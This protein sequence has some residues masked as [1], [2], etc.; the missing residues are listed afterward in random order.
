MR[1]VLKFMPLLLILIMVFFTY[2]QVL[3]FDYLWD[4]DL[5]I[6]DNVDLV[7]SQLNWDIISRPVLQG[8]S[9]FRPLVFL[10]WFIEFKLFG[11]SSATS[12]LINLIIFLINIGLVY[13]LAYLLGKATQKENL[14]LLASLC[15]GLYAIHPIHV[16]TTAWV[17]GR[18][19][20]M[21]TLFTLLACILFISQWLR[22][23]SS[24]YINF[25]IGVC[26][27]CA[28]MSK[29]LGLVV[30]ILIFILYLAVCSDG[31]RANFIGF[32][33]QY[34][35]LVGFIGI[36]F[37]IY[38]MLRMYSM[39]ETYHYPF[40]WEYYNTI[41]FDQ[42]VPLYAIKQY[43]LQALLPFYTLGPIQPTELFTVRNLINII[44][45]IL[46]SIFLIY[47][48]INAVR[49]NSFFS[50]MMLS[51][52]VTISLVIF[53]IPISSGNNI[54]QERFMTLGLTF[55][56][57]GIVF[58]LSKLRKKSWKIL[59]VTFL[60]IWSIGAYATTKSILPFWKNE[61][62]LWGWVYKSYPNNYIIRNLYY[63][64]LLKYN[65]LD[66]L[67]LIVNKNTISQ[68]KSLHI[69]DQV[70]Y[71]KALLIRRHPES[72]EYLRGVITSI[73]EFHKL[74][75]NNILSNALNASSYLQLT[76]LQIATA[77]DSLSIA[78]LWFEN[79][80]EQALKYNYIAEQYLEPSEKYPVLYNRIAFFKILGRQEEVD[81]LAK[82]VDM[83]EMYRK[84]DNVQNIGKIIKIWCEIN[85]IQQ[86]CES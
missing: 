43:F 76:P 61:M 38:Y 83:I 37:T 42:Q 65:H 19:D 29:E 35:I 56:I 6:V 34:Y 36:F 86:K 25:L 1:I 24:L 16:E 48:A 51:Y 15:A 57:I 64:S 52:L 77:Y 13:W 53:L 70:L 22:S 47:L 68:G 44:S 74:D 21:A 73:P 54:I 72:L 23:Q 17:S 40:T 75:S 8:S 80:P 2:K 18:F 12:H 27:F 49:K 39:Q 14:V 84:N 63:F 58:T 31:F 79:N 33:K 60:L 85:H 7:N 46:I 5:L 82:Q 55:F 67:I 3:S 30:P 45:I 59:I 26:Y 9:Y 50:W 32:F 4:D 41:V 28:L 78:T 66:D 10:S 11:Q 20:L 69:A 62:T 81:I 71:G